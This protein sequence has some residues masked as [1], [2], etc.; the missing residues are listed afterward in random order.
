MSAGTAVSDR[1]LQSVVVPLQV[2]TDGQEIAAALGSCMS[3]PNSMAI[4]S[5]LQAGFREKQQG[6]RR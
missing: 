5:S 3:A 4:Q 1:A 2:H 6:E